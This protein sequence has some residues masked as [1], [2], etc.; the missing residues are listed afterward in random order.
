MTLIDNLETITG[1]KTKYII[2]V[3]DGM[4]DYPCK[5][6]SGKTPLEAARTPFMDSLS[7]I[8]ETGRLMTVPNGFYPGSDVANMSLMG[9]NPDEFYTGRGP[10]EAA[11]MGIPM[12]P[13][14]VAFRCNLVTLAFREGKVYMEDYSAGHISS[15]EAHILLKDLSALIP[16]RSFSLHPGV[17]YRHILLWMGGPEGLSTVAPHDHTGMDVSAAWHLYEE[18]PTLY[19]LLTKAV[20]L[21]HSHPLNKKRVA[22]G[23]LPANSIWPWGQGRK[24]AMPRFI[25]LYGLKGAVIS[26]VDLIKGLGVLAGMEFISVPGATGFLDTNYQGKADAAINALSDH[27]FVFVHVEAPDEA[28]H[29]GNLKEK[30]MAIE[31]F[32][33]EVV[34]RVLDGLRE[35]GGHFRL[36]I[37]TDHYTPVTLKTHSNDPVPF[38]IY[39]SLDPKEHNDA[40]FNEKYA[41]TSPIF[42]KQGH[43]VLERLLGVAKV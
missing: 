2:L 16:S 9:Y 7:R 43:K 17:S 11:A 25:D 36:M 32:D 38:I 33:K 35:K 28:G 23:K 42:L 10:I 13:E 37:A 30:I 20:T 40:L 24:P 26:A 5:E 12:N 8:G 27:D 22:E 29:M 34:G 18:E 6:L 4:G 39:D 41:A 31:N 15:E 19:D 14:D 21:F 1:S 3:G